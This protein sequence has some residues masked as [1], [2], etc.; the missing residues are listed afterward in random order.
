M[1]SFEPVKYCEGLLKSYDS[2]SLA[3]LDQAL[4]KVKLKLE[5]ERDECLDSINKVQQGVQDK[6][7]IDIVYKL[8]DRQS[9]ANRG[10]EAARFMVKEL[11]T[12]YAEISRILEEKEMQRKNAILVRDLVIE[13]DHYNVSQGDIDIDPKHLIYLKHSLEVMD[14]PE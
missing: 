4:A 14:I 12:E 7:G 13:L 3:S 1:E 5:K 6:G 9:K 11:N 8:L 2:V 10:L